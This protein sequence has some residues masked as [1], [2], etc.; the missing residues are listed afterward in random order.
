MIELGKK[1]KDK[2]TGFEGL[3]TG[4]AQYI[5]GCDQYLLTPQVSDSGTLQESRWVDEGRVE[6]IGEGIYPGLVKIPDQNGG[7]A[8]WPAPTK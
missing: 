1:A 7:P 4:R 2:I 6:V 5:T 3:L 8:E